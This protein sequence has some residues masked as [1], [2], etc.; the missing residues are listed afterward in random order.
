MGETMIKC[1]GV[2]KEYRL[3]G[4]IIRAL[5]DIDLEIDAGEFIIVQGPTGCGKTTLLNVMSGLDL[6]DDGSVILDGEDIARASEDRLSNIRRQKVGFVFQDF[7]L[8]ENLT[9]IENV[10]ALLWPTVL[11]NKDIEDRAIAALRNVD[12]LERKDHFPRDL[13]GG[14]RQRVGIARAIIHQPRVLFADE[15]TGNLDPASAKMVMDLLKTLNKDMGM[16]CIVVTHDANLTKYG[17]RVIKMDK[18]RIV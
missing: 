17:D 2:Q 7:N 1:I 4:N 9:A 14:E 3:R 6:P 5:V 18:G 10:E 16:T 11:K 12:M 13:S 8:I 15:P